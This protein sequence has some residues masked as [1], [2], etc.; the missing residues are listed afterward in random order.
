MAE[1]VS[2]HIYQQCSCRVWLS[3]YTHLSAMFMSCMAELVHTFISNVHVMAESVS[4]HIYQQCSCHAWLS[5]LV[6]TFISNVH[7][8]AESVTALIY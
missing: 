8:M 7:V 1:S 2:A 6:H 5:Q 3:Q 4:A